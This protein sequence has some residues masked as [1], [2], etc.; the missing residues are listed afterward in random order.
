MKQSLAEEMRIAGCDTIDLLHIPSWNE[1]ICR[2]DEIE[3]M[4]GILRP[5]EI[6]IPAY[7]PDDRIGK[8][9]RSIILD[10]CSQ[11]SITELSICSTKFIRKNNQRGNARVIVSPLKDYKLSED[12]DLVEL[13]SQGKFSM[14][15][16]GF[17]NS[18]EIAFDIAQ[19]GAIRNVDLFL[20]GQ[21][22]WS[23]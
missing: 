1:K 15:S 21:D 6:E 9:C 22:S 17:V 7:I 19:I 11:S 3:E 13:F 5:T 4:L 23:Q 20:R 8:R 12:N 18:Q 10:Y 16:T 2:A 14:L